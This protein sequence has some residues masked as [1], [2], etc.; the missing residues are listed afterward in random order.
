MFLGL[1]LASAMG[2]AAQT[3]FVDHV[4][5]TE[6]RI[7]TLVERGI[8]RSATFRRL[9]DTLNA[10]DVIVYI[11]PKRNRC[12]L[13]G[14]LTHRVVAGGATRYLRIAVEVHGGDDRLI[15]LVAH[16]LQHAV[17]V[18]QSPART[19]AAV[20]LL[21]ERSSAGETC[22]G[23]YETDAAIEIQEAVLGELRVKQPAAKAV[24]R[25]EDAL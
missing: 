1:A 18:A 2:L 15:G 24:S 7:L 23:C 22:G 4:R 14:Y 3:A 6:P 5:S 16:E 25:R 20:V 11:E 13:G 17:E 12:A 21:F 10:S 8:A 9:I 19:S